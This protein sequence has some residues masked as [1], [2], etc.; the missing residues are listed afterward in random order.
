MKFGIVIF[1]GS[2]CERDCYHVIKNVLHQPVEYIWHA[3]T[4]LADFSCI[5]LPGGFSYGDY[6]RAGAIA[7]FAN[8]ME[9]IKEFAENGGYVIG[10]CNG[11]QI[12]TESGLLPGALQRNRDLKFICKNIPLRVE[13]TKTPFT[14]RYQEGQVVNIPVAHM[15]GNY[16]VDKKKLASMKKSGQ[17]IFRYCN[18]EGEV[19][20]ASN[21]N[22]SIAN[23]AGI[24]NRKK[25]VIGMMPHPERV[26]EK[27][28]GCDDGVHIF[29][30]ILENMLKVK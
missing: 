28:L 14:S 15:E 12:L 29:L 13:N 24:C 5:I 23:I 25:N 4:E 16:T 9:K 10:I 2:N 19:D 18:A 8:I 1:P 3:D 27:E 17:I 21:P 6:L 7:H 26:S 20:E 11:F 22:G 30:A